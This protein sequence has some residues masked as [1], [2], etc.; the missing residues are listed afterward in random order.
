MMVV[1]SP[2]PAIILSSCHWSGFLLLWACSSYH[3]DIGTEA[4]GQE[5]WDMN[6]QTA[7]LDLE[8]AVGECHSMSVEHKSLRSLVNVPCFAPHTNVSRAAR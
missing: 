4:L 6:N 8:L 2:K 5:P 1:G 7:G 3:L